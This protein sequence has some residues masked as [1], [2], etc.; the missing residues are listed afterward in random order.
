[1]MGKDKGEQESW[2]VVEGF[3]RGHRLQFAA[4]QGSMPVVQWMRWP[5]LLRTLS[6]APRMAAREKPCWR[7]TGMTVERA[8]W[9]ACLEEELTEKRKISPYKSPLKEVEG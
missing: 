4:P 2:K 6:L 7:Q 8:C 9:K 3:T 1:M 5:V